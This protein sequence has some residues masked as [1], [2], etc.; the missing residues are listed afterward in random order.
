MFSKS[1]DTSQG[2]SDLELL[3]YLSKY[4]S[5]SF[6]KEDLDEV[7]MEGFTRRD[8]LQVEVWEHKNLTPSY[9]LFGTSHMALADR[10][11]IKEASSFENKYGNIPK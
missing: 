9:V 2:L 4:S 1:T 8:Q 3:D 6:T 10:E 11:A 5:F 7:L